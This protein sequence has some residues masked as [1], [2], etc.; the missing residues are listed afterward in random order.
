MRGG[1]VALADKALTFR[2]VYQ[3]LTNKAVSF[4]FPALTGGTGDSLSV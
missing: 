3:K 2:A 4:E 1:I